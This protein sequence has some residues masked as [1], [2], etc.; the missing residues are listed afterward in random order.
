MSARSTQRQGEIDEVNGEAPVTD[1]GR[2][3]D[4]DND[5]EDV[6][7]RRWVCGERWVSFGHDLNGVGCDMET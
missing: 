7:E 1:S 6:E 5:N 3:E 4:E 2:G